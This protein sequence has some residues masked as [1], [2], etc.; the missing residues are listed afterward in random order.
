MHRKKL[1]KH[2]KIITI[3]REHPNESIAILVKSRTHL[4]FILPALQN[5]HIDY[6]GIDLESLGHKPIVEDLWSLTQALLQID[7]RLAY[8]NILRAPWC[9]L[10][11]ADLQALATLYP[12]GSLYPA[13]TQT[14]AFKTFTPDGWER[15]KKCAHIVKYA[16]DNRARQ[17][18][19]NWVEQTW[20]HLK[21]PNCLQ[22]ETEHRQ[23][24]TFLDLLEQHDI[25]GQLRDVTRF[26][27]KL[28]RLY[29]S[30]VSTSHVSIMT[31]HKAKGLEFDVVILPSLEQA[32]ASGQSELLLWSQRP[33]EHGDNDLIL[34]PMQASD[35]GEPDLLYN[36]LKKEDKQKEAYE[37]LRLLY[38]ASTR[39]KQHLYLLATHNEEEIPS[40]EKF[41]GRTLTRDTKRLD[42][43]FD[44]YFYRNR[45]PSYERYRTPTLSSF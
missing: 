3:I 24:E 9:G 19:R 30:Q 38:V 18:L 33:S 40:S 27:E 11:L 8:F 23:A 29:S 37:R 15:F 44:A 42:T 12:K 22:T 20:H 26:S 31:I 45:I 35:H 14:S 21:G 4:Q 43:M 25:G 5:A 32:S 34:A 6:Q 17:S 7:N 28:N 41:F 10:C 16:I 1:S 13:F 2:K 36:Y 39:A